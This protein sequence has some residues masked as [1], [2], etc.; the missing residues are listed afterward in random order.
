MRGAVSKASGREFLLVHP[1]PSAAKVIVGIIR[2]CGATTVRRFENGRQA[3]ELVRREKGDV[4]IVDEIAADPDP[5]RIA[6]EINATVRTRA[7]PPTIL[8]TTTP[9]RQL[10][11]AALSGGFGSVIAKPFSV[12][13]LTAHVAHA[14]K[15]LR[16]SER[17]LADR[18]LV[19]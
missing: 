7:L 2:Q 4:V 1:D 9:T 13:T 8:M 11:E 5:W 19:D 15:A 10:L 18:F 14:L 6:D 16:L 12:R 17:D 3:I